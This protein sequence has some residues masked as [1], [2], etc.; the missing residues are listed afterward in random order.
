MKH[1]YIIAVQF[2]DSRAS[3]DRVA[4]TE[5]KK[6]IDNY[7][8]RSLIARNKKEITGYSYPNDLTLEVDLSSEAKLDNPTRALRLLSEYLVKQTTLGDYVSGKQLFKMAVKEETK[9]NKGAE[10]DFRTLSPEEREEA[11]YNVLCA[12][13][14]ELKEVKLCLASQQV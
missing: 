13:K 10:S 1:N 2:A 11:I 7:N 9:E 12:I 14:N 5:V 6:A 4:Q 8:K 3:F